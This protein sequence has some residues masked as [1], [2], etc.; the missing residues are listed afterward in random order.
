NSFQNPYNNFNNQTRVNGYSPQIQTR[1]NNIY[2]RLVNRDFPGAATRNNY[3]APNVN[4]NRGFQQPNVQQFNSPYSQQNQIQ[5]PNN[6]YR[7]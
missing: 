6:G 1:I 5:Y 2:D 3:T 4:I 7:Y